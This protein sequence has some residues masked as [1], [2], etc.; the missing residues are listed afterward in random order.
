MIKMKHVKLFVMALVCLFVSAACFAD[1]KMIPVEQLPATVKTFIKQHFPQKT[2]LYAEKD[3]EIRG[4][5]Y[6]VRLNDGTE[7]NFDKKGNWD[8]IDCKRV[9]VPAVF[10]P[11]AIATYVQTNFPGDIIVK[12]DKERYGYEI[13]LLSDLELKFNKKGQLISMDD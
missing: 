7:V 10:I 12:I 13:E 2:I 8:K 3:S 6:E 9:A 5:K 1:D 4:V 11:Q